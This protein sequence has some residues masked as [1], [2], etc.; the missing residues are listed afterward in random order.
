MEPRTAQRARSLWLATEPLHAVCYFD[1]DCRALGKDLGLKGF[2]MGYFAT[3]IAPLGAVAPALATSVLGVFAPCMVA[4]AL[5]AAWNI[6]SPDRVL[7]E[8][9]TRAARA[10]RAIHPG[11]DRSATALL[12]RLQALVDNAPDTARPLFAANR[13][14]R[15]QADPVERLWQ[16][17]TTLRE[18]RGDVHLAVLADREL[19]ACEALVLAA[20]TGRVPRDTMRVDRGWTEEE[21][22]AATDRLRARNLVDAHGAATALG[23]SAR[24]RIEEDTDRLAARLLRP[25]PPAESDHLLELLTPLARRVLAADLLP[26]P[27]PIGLPRPDTP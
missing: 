12:P 27:N 10:L 6:V 15:D 19:D 2:W 11:L 21:W 14:L 13:A 22:A 25:L 17:A 1:D 20:A 26:F 24:T 9:G 23:R 8:R 16:L 5:P 3:R 18:F 4:R 7:G